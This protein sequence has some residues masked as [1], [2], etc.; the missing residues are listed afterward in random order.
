M[1]RVLI[2]HMCLLTNQAADSMSHDQLYPIIVQEL[3]KKKCLGGNMHV[4]EDPKYHRV[5]LRNV[6]KQIDGVRSGLESV[7]ER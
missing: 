3:K 5:V 2:N 6:Q 4:Q 7:E 1:S